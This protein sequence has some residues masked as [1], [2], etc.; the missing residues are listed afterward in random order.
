MGDVC[1]WPDK[2]LYL[3]FA[4]RAGFCLLQG[5]LQSFSQQSD[6]GNCRRSWLKEKACTEQPKYPSTMSPSTVGAY[7]E[8][9]S[10]LR[11]LHVVHHKTPASEEA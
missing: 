7:R 5:R 10:R 3:S 6:R 8:R 2:K 1:K 4:L 11:K 9:D